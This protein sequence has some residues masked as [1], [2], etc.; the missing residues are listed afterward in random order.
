MP[1]N[2]TANIHKCVELT[3]LTI[4]AKPTLEHITRES[5]TW[6][7]IMWRAFQLAFPRLAHCSQLRSGS[8]NPTKGD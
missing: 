5:T 7:I 3:A 2:L 1:V 6:S 4:H 8:N